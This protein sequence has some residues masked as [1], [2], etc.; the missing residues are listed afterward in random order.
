MSN[1]YLVVEHDTAWDWEREDVVLTSPSKELCERAV[2]ILTKL[3]EPNDSYRIEF[4][5]KTTKLVNTY[6]EMTELIK[7]E[8]MED[9]DDVED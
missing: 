2:D 1:L 7:E 3:A 6:G 4:Y 5:V 8:Y 9:E